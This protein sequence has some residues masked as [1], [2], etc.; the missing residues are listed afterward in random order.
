MTRRRTGAG[1]GAANKDTDV[2]THKE[3]PILTMEEAGR[4]LGKDGQTVKRWCASGCLPYVMFPNKT[5]GVRES[6]VN[7]HLRTIQG[8]PD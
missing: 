3:D 6:V 8:S 5:F 2:K 1:A 7:S 4:R